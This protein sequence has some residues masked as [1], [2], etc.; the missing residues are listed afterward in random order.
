MKSCSA[1]FVLLW[2][3]P[4]AAQPAVQSN[5]PIVAK[6]TYHK[7]NSHSETILDK[8]T[9]ELIESTYNANNVLVAKK[10]Y[11][12]NERGLPTQG[13]IYDGRGNLVAR[14]QVY[15]DDFGRAKEMRSFNLNGQCYQQILYEYDPSTGAAKKPIVNN[16]DPRAAPTIRP[17]VMDF[18]Q[19]TAPPGQVPPSQMTPQMQ[20][21]YQQQQ[22]QL[23]LQY[24]QQQ[25][26][27]P[28]PEAP[29]PKGF[30]KRLFGK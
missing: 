10:H 3:T 30:F 7:D 18:T 15:F 20:M 14:S 19:T 8:T 21:Q 26:A 5:A 4:A 17:D 28:P 23:Q 22:Q 25:R 11:L 9:N 12:L 16:V 24:Q 6:S 2:L 29:K 13:H 1:F 27:A